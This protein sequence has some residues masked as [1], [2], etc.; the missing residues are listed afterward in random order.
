MSNRCLALLTCVLLSACSLGRIVQPTLSGE[1][2]YSA[3]GAA[4]RVLTAA[5]CSAGD[6]EYYLGMDLIAPDWHLRA[7]RDPLGQTTV[8]F[9]HPDGRS[10]LTA[11]Q[12]QP[13]QFAIRPSG[14]EVNDVR[15]FAI[16]LRLDCQLSG[17]AR[18]QGH[19]IVDHCH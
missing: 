18:L 3:P 16:D 6:R 1:M 14:W 8:I 15:D 2:R 13:L 19:M 4:P 12:C 9:D 11:A 10:V 17:D 5:Q 7:V